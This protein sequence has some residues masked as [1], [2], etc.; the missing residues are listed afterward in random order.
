MSRTPVTLDCLGVSLAVASVTVDTNL[1]ER[2]LAAQRQ[3]LLPLTAPMLLSIAAF[4]QAKVV[5]HRNSQHMFCTV[6]DL[7][8][9]RNMLC[10]A[11]G[12]NKAAERYRQRA[13]PSPPPR[14]TPGSRWPAHRKPLPR[15][16][17]CVL[18]LLCSASFVAAAH[19][20]C[21]PC[22][23]CRHARWPIAARLRLRSGWRCVCCISIR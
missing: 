3:Q 21:R 11:Q 15:R 17:G 13:V 5:I 10:V 19:S 7:F 18:P 9:Y 14:S 8:V 22:G 4:H 6:S 2:A 20:L 12:D 1:L 23:Q 16:C